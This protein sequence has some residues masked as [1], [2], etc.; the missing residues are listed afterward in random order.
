MTLITPVSVAVM[1]LLAGCGLAIAGIYLL[2]GLGW[3][4]IAGAAPLLLFA[5]L[6]LR[7]LQRAKQI[8]Q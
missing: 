1:A 2:A 7:G 3:S 5:F 6:L 8:T 4:L